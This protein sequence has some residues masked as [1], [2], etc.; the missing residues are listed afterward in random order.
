MTKTEFREQFKRL[1]L[2]GYRLPLFD[3]VT[4][5]DVMSEWYD[6]FSNCTAE[7]FSQA[8]DRLKQ[9]KTDTWWP[10]TGEIWAQVFEVRKARKVRASMDDHGEF[11]ETPA[12]VRAQLAAGFREFAAQLSQRMRMPQVEPQAE[13]EHV[14][15]EREARARQAAEES[16]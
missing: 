12:E 4:I 1:R 7:E 10:A 6:T 3:G 2:A 11:P 14:I 8:I 9:Q 16:A 15:E 13:P 5:E